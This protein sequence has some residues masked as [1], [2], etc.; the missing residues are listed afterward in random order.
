MRLVSELG[1]L[2]CFQRTVISHVPRAAVVPERDSA[3][4]LKFGLLVI[5]IYELFSGKAK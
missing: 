3:S 1:F 4:F 2:R 5:D